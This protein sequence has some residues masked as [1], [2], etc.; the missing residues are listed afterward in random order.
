LVGRAKNGTEER[1]V[2]F[3]QLTG[4]TSP[5]EQVHCGH[6]AHKTDQSEP[7]EF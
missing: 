1:A 2:N 4:Q 7:I 5:G 6:T 3:S